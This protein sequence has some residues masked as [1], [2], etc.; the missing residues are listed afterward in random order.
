MDKVLLVFKREPGRVSKLSNFPCTEQCGSN[1]GMVCTECVSKYVLNGLRST[2][3]S[4]SPTHAAGGPC[5]LQCAV[6]PQRRAGL[7]TAL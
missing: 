5:T 2:P 6:F 4:S 3:P 1:N 7:P